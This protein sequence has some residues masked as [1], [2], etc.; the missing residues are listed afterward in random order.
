MKIMNDKKK[1]PQYIFETSW[2]SI[3]DLD[4]AREV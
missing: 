3:Y 2:G 4:I 1:R